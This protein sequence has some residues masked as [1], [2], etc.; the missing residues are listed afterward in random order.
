M[1]FGGGGKGKEHNRESTILKCIT[2]VH[3]EDITICTESC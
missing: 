3:A 1:E 2:S